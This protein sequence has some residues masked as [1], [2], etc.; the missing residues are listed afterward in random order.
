VPCEPW[1]KITSSSLPIPTLIAFLPR[2]S[3]F[4]QGV[5]PVSKSYLYP[6]AIHRLQRQ[7]QPEVAGS[8]TLDLDIM[9]LSQHYAEMAQTLR[10]F[11]PLTCCW[12]SPE[13]VKP[14]GNHPIAAGGYANVWEARYDG[15]R[16]V[17]KSYRCYVTFDVTRVTRVCYHPRQTVRC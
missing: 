7:P 10:P 4:V 15:R 8:H 13:D 2:L 17:L 12:L 16:V 5:S 11:M 9:T 6:Q 3:A 1:Y 14:I